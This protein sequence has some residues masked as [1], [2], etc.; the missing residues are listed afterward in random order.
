M[1]MTTV[2]LKEFRAEVELALAAVAEKYGCEVAAGNIKYDTTSVDLTLY[3]KSKGENGESAEELDFKKHCKSYGFLPEDYGAL[4]DIE[5]KLYQFIGF[6]PR[7]RKNYCIIRD[8]AGKE[9]ATSIPT[10]QL[11]LRGVVG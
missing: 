8:A 10:I 4:I 11:N 2:D 6:N 3:F 1:N 5:G 7:A 9:Y